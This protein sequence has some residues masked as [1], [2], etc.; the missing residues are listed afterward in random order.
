MVHTWGRG[1]SVLGGGMFPLAPLGSACFLLSLVDAAKAVLRLC[2][3]MRR[4]GHTH[5]ACWRGIP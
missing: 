1:L 4:S 3:R 5:Q 2:G